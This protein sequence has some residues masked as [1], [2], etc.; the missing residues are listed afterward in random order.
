MAEKISVLELILSFSPY[1]RSPK[2]RFPFETTGSNG[3]RCVSQSV[4]EGHYQDGSRNN[5]T[6]KNRN[7]PISNI[8]GLTEYE[9]LS[10]IYVTTFCNCAGNLLISIDWSHVI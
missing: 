3:C 9:I 10:D 6:S 1:L 4:K 7:C 2:V 5:V 8:V